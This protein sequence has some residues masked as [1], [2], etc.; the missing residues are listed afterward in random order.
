LGDIVSAKTDFLAH[1]GLQNS[2][3]E[4]VIHPLF[5]NNS[6]FDPLDTPQLRYEMLR[7]ARSGETSVS[8]SCELFGLSREYFYQ[9]ERSF[10][11]R[12]LVGLLS[13]PV[14]R[15]PILSLNQNIV[16]HVAHRK[17]EQP[18]LSGEDIRLEILEIFKVTCSRRTVERIIEKLGFEKKGS[19]VH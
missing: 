7:S 9:M 3:P 4:R 12:G 13:G 11:E 5:K 10:S 19:P 17:A 6:F 2:K 8:K 14:G 16:N 15:R 18:S 1:Q